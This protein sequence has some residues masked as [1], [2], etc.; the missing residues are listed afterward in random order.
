MWAFSPAAASGGYSLAE[1]RGLLLA[2][3]SLAV[4]QR[5]QGTW[6]SLVAAHWLSSCDSW[7]IEH[8]L[9]S[10]GTQV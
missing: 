5:L 7:T 2:V 8:R 9:N 1:A 10:C 4:E 3:T 6:T